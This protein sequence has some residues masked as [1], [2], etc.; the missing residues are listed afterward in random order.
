MRVA[1]LGLGEAGS[2][3]ARDL[4]VAGAEVR[5][6]DPQD[7]AT[8]EGVERTGDPA[9]AVQEAEVTLS[10]TSGADVR[11]AMDQAWNALTPGTLYADLATASPEIEVGLAERARERDTEFAD[12]ALMAPVPGRGLGTPALASGTGAK[13]LATL[14]NPMGAKVTVIGDVAGAASGRKLLRSV[15]TKGLAALLVEAGEA[16][17]AH[18][19]GDWLIDHLT[20]FLTSLD[21]AIVERLVSST[22]HHAGRRLDE[23]QTASSFLTGLGVEPHMAR[24]T[25]ERLRPFA[26]S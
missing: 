18:G 14:L 7:V 26:Q 20:D 6:F 1:I 4:V 9:E 12:V 10:I 22:S 2:L 19:D 11:R 17:A 3:I 23:M 24:A 5:G 16:G 25:I 13:R 21:R 15:V 8:P